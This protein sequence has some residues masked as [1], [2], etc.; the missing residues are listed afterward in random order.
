MTDNSIDDLINEIKAQRE[1]MFTQAKNVIGGSLLRDDFYFLSLVDRCIR[2]S[3]GFVEMISS[4]NIMCLG[5]LLRCLLD[6]IMRLFAYFI[7]EDRDELVQIFLKDEKKIDTLKDR[8]GK[9][10][11][12]WYLKEELRILDNRF[13]GV[14]NAASGYVHHSGKSL[15][16]IAD[17][18][19][20]YRIEMVIGGE[21]PQRNN[22]HLQ[23]C[24]KAFMHYLLLQQD[25][26]DRIILAKMEFDR[27]KEDN[28]VVLAHK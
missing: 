11:F 12:D 22:I 28:D 17:A 21:I 24:A 3:D 20:D 8:K 23:E 16:S 27:N 4:R 1:I 5:I 2:L 13:V 15:F 18:L 26:V 19:E 9:R 7:A 25:L 6:N 10:M 14:Y